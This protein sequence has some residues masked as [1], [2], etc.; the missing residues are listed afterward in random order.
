MTAHSMT[1]VTQKATKKKNKN[2]KRPNLLYWLPLKMAQGTWGGTH[3]SG[4]RVLFCAFSCRGRCLSVDYFGVTQGCSEAQETMWCLG[5]NW[6]PL[7]VRCWCH[8]LWPLKHFVWKW[9]IIKRLCCFSKVNRA[10]CRRVTIVSQ[11][12]SCL[13]GLPLY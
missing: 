7:H 11:N 4:A 9:R 2:K 1:G 5:I 3:V 12:I 6:D 10:F 8:W 13:A